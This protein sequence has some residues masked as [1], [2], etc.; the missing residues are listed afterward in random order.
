MRALT[1][2]ALVATLTLGCDP[3][4]LDAQVDA[5]DIAHAHEQHG[6]DQWRGGEGTPQHTWDRYVF[7]ARAV[8]RYLRAVARARIESC[9]RDVHCAI[10]LSSFFR[11]APWWLMDSIARCESNYRP[12]ARSPTSTASGVYQW[13][14]SS[15]VSYS[16]RAGHGGKSV[17]D[18]WAN[19]DTA[20]H[21]IA[22]GGPG[23]WAAS[24]HCWG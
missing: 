23:P 10:R 3:P 13:I 7:E 11:G 5:H 16:A 19:V 20:G 9:A 15:W 18:V 2:L 4:E 24:Q 12:D 14:A 6:H 8:N 17:F 1:A 22:T 21:A